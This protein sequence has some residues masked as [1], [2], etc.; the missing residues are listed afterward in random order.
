MESET[1]RF[2]LFLRFER[3][4]DGVV[5]SA[6]SDRMGGNKGAPDSA[7]NGSSAT[8]HLMAEMLALKSNMG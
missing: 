7:V 1:L 5:E 6:A 2:A 3:F 4:V 8:V